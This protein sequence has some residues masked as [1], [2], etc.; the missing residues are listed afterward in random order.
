MLFFPFLLWSILGHGFRY[1]RLYL[2][3]SA[4][5]SAILFIAVVLNAPAWQGFAA[6]DVGLVL[7]LIM[8]PAYFAVLLGRSRARSP[9][10]R[11]RAAPRAASSPP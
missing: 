3:V 1:G 10:P 2:A 8:L 11:T 5:S 4:V 6:L 7:S 9:G